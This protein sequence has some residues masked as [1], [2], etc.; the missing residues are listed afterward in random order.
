V[1]QPVRY[2][3]LELLAA[4]SQPLPGGN[5]GSHARGGA[6]EVRPPLKREPAEALVT[7]RSRNPRSSGRGGCQVPVERHAGTKQAEREAALGASAPSFGPMIPA[8]RVYELNGVLSSSTSLIQT[9]PLPSMTRFS[10]IR[11]GR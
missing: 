2:T 1:S 4:G 10:L 8:V 9:L 6:A 7:W 3:G 5:R 11:S